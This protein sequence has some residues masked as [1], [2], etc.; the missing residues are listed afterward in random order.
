MRS[1]PDGELAR[2]LEELRKSGV[3]VIEGVLSTREARDA[4]AALVAAARES[5][6][7]GAA[8]FMPEL[9][10]NDANVRVF[11]LLDLHAIFRDVIVHPVA[12]ALVRGLLGEHFA[13]SNFTANIARP[14]SR[15][16]SIH[17]DQALVA[18]EPWLAPWSMN[19]IWCLDDVTAENGGTLYLPGSQRFTQR[20]ALPP[21]A[22]A[23]MRPFTA[24]CGSIVAMDGRVWHTSGANVTRDAER[25]LLFG[26]YSVDFLRPQTNFNVNLSDAT[27]AQLSPEL[28]TLLGLGPSGN[29]RVAG[30]VLGERPRPPEARA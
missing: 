5:E 29:T 19:V 10:P 15:S 3:A 1:T 12:L 27:K 28:F 11:N 26:Y 22:L 13:I 23:Q 7:R 9:D 2:A 20:A 21:D 16:M 17:S 25:A 8:T 4:R 18:P 6:R 24:P 30:E 14:G